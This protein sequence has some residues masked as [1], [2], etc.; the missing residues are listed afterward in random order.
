MSE[1]KHTPGPWE[2][3]F[4][5]ELKS[6]LI[7]TADRQ[8]A[9]ARMEQFD[10]TP[11]DATQRANARLIAAAP[12]MYAALKDLRSYIIAYDGPHS[13]ADLARI[14]ATISLA[15]GNR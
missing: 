8:T 11:N 4:V 14:D 3:V 10:G 9:F 13:A 5:P 6:V 15:E 7:G 2:A 12:A 1:A